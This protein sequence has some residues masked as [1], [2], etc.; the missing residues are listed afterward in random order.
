[1]KNLLKNYSAIFILI[2]LFTSCKK[3]YEDP[4]I[5]TV[6]TG[7]VQTIAQVRALYQPGKTIK[8]AEDISVYG[9]V[10]MDESTG[11]LYKESYITDG[12]GNLYL[13]FTTGSGLYIG[14]S[15]RVNLNGAKILKYNQ[16]LQVDSLH[17]DNSVVKLSTQNYVTPETISISSL[18]ADLEGSQGKLVKIDGAFFA[19]GGLGLS[20]ADGENQVS[21]SRYLFALNGDEI[22]V[23][24][25]GYSNFADDTL[26]SG[27]GKFIGVVAQYNDGLQLLIRDPQELEMD[28]EAPLLK[29]FNDQSITSGGWTT[30][31]VTGPFNWITND[32]GSSSH[33]AALTNYDNGNTASEV[34]LISPSFNFSNSTAQSL[35]FKNAS[36]YNGPDIEVYVSTNYDGA[37]LPN[38]ATWSQLSANLSGGGFEWVSSGIINLSSF[39]GANTY[40]AIKYTGTASDGKTWELD[41]IIINK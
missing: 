21:E 26:P 7:S 13:R 22:E 1:M 10:T 40:I 30:Q 32:Q 11:N 41:N 35:S 28:G 20:Y 36:N 38:T 3:D 15:V 29:T 14:D 6:A 9:V 33:Y 8:I 16:M 34:W 2:A 19:E 31:V 39:T 23:R 12:T 18:L 25:S 27:S 4:T 17:P 24:T 5:K 37:S